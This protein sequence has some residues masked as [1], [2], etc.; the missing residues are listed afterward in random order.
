MPFVISGSPIRDASFCGTRSITAMPTKPTMINADRPTEKYCFDCLTLP[1]ANASDIRR[2]SATG[3]PAVDIVSR[4][5]YM[6]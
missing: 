4:R 1:V 6:T 3:T 5:L 2:E